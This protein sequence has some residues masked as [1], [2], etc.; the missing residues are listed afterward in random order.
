MPSSAPRSRRVPRCSYSERGRRCNLSGIGNPPL[1]HAHRIIVH[2][3]A[4]AAGAS[5]NPG[6]PIVDAIHDMMQGKPINVDDFGRAAAQTIWEIG[7]GIASAFV[8]DMIPNLP[9]DAFDPT[10]GWSG[11]T[12]TS[13]GHNP[14]PPPPPD[15]TPE[16]EILRAR[17]VLGFKAGQ[18][19]TEDAIKQRQREL[20]KKH[21]PDRGGKVEKMQQINAAVDT[22]MAALSP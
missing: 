6:Q 21:H 13:A 8:P 17:R 11:T 18:V 22:L 1:C 7:Q 10:R 19:L 20:A 5:R 15:P 14:P 2:D 3:A 4:R 16:L 12:S 9:R